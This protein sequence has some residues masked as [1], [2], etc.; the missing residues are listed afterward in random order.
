MFDVT[1]II[2]KFPSRYPVMLQG[3]LKRNE[4]EKKT[5]HIRKSVSYISAFRCSSHQKTAVTDL[6]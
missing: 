1:K 3:K 2:S 5:L 4:K 6:G